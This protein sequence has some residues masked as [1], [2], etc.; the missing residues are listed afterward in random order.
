MY[1]SPPKNSRHSRESQIVFSKSLQIEAVFFSFGVPNCRCVNQIY[2]F[3]GVT[4]RRVPLFVH[5]F[6]YFDINKCRISC[7]VNFIY[8]FLSHSKKNKEFEHFLQFV[9][10]AQFRGQIF[11]TLKARQGRAPL[12]V[13]NRFQIPL[14]QIPI[15]CF[16]FRVYPPA[17]GNEK[18]SD[19]TW[20]RC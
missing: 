7:V 15:F 17:S 19:D 10:V 12:G 20:H 5:I 9:R 16:V 6:V 11:Y 2:P 8:L 14:P 13:R 1:A 18:S 4:D 3:C